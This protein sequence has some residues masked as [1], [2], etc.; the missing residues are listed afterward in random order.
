MKNNLTIVKVSGDILT[1][2]FNNTRD[3][4]YFL[5]D[6]F[7]EMVDISLLFNKEEVLIRISDI[8]FSRE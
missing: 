2:F 6:K 7:K 8:L 1:S 4:L 3:G 5:L